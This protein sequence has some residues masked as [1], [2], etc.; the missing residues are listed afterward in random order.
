MAQTGEIINRVEKSPLLTINLE[1]YYPHGERVQ[2][3][4]APWLFQGMILKEKDFRAEVKEHDWSKYQD[5][6]VA[7]T[8]SADAIVPTWAYMLIASKLQE[9][10]KMFIFGSK[11][12]L[13]KILFKNSLEKINP[14]DYTDKKLVIKGCS[15]LKITEFAYVEIVRLLKPVASS[16]MY[17]EPCST[18]PIYKAPR[19]K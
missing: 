8:C 13:E 10:A 2:L 11:T 1:D 7:I 17:G 15:D 6:F 9:Y 3:D 5:Q 18:V 4:I 14:E 16:I 19:K 12:E